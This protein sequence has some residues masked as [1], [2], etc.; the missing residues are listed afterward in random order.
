MGFIVLCAC[1]AF[2]VQLTALHFISPKRR[3]LRVLPLVVMELLPAGL[4]A[5]AFITKKPGGI[6]GWQFT[7]A[8]SGWM[9]QAI[10]IGCV[11]AGMMYISSTK[12]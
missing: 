1:L 9:A 12:K 6:L 5:H 3:V 10:L 11:I 4:A 8:A 7:I 2:T